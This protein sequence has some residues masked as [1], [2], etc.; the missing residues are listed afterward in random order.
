M[1]VT[2]PG[3]RLHNKRELKLFYLD[4]FKALEEHEVSYLLIGGLAM[5]LHGIPR[6]TMDVDIV[7]ILENKNL[8]AFIAAA[9]S[10]GLQPEIPVMLE[11]LK[12]PSARKNWVTD[13]NLI[14]LPLK[15]NQPDS[16]TVDIILKHPLDIDTAMQQ[17]TI[18]NIDGISVRLASINDMIT[19][20]SFS[21]RKQDLSDLEHLKR[22]AKNEQ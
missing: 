2:Q 15:N 13:K 17:A 21:G 22:I 19:L 18:K 3:L 11:D 9:Q 6:M 8:S 7:L 1:V 16:P 14:A 20:K 4:L 5:N 12:N 10:L